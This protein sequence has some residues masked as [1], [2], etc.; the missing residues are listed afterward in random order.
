MQ[1]KTVGF[2]FHDFSQGGI[3]RVLA[4]L[5][6]ILVNGGYRVVM[7]TTI[8]AHS[9]EYD[10]P[11]DFDRITIGRYTPD[12][13]RGRLMREAIVKHKIDL[14]IHHE[15]YLSTLEEDVKVLEE[16]GVPFLIHLHNV[17]SNMYMRDN[18]QLDTLRFWQLYQRTDGLLVL[19]RVDKA[20]VSMLGIRAFY[21]PNPVDRISAPVRENDANRHVILWFA[22]FTDV[23]QPTHAL[24]IF[25]KV[26]ESVPDAEMYMLG[27]PQSQVWGKKSL[28]W[29]QKK[30]NVAG[31][32][33][34]EGFQPNVFKYLRMSDVTLVTSKF[35]GFCLTIME[36]KACAVPVVSYAM[37]YLE[38]TFP[39]EGVVSVP[40]GDV[41][42][43]AAE[44]IKVLSD[45]EYAARIADAGR[46]AYE[47]YMNIDLLAE[48]RKVFSDIE[49]CP[50]QRAI[51]REYTRNRIMLETLLLHVD[52]ALRMFQGK[53]G[54]LDKLLAAANAKAASLA[55][56]VDELKSRTVAG[57]AC[58]QD[59]KVV[60]DDAD[61]K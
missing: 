57:C 53:I 40:Q 39:D 6:R 58:S 15:Y 35:E 19:S 61:G 18:R 51:D 1:I 7:L 47:R 44:I 30:P 8:S 48:Y 25:E 29:V 49:A 4:N 27:D 50:R 21:M 24:Q 17:F 12:G 43:A 41:A 54:R 31:K 52:S 36:S 23:K 45:R 14:V 56:Q 26:L 60:G 38:T 10:V 34:F 3:Q 16:S 46:R 59:S 22:R 37:P 32:I 9:N 33:H 11:V 55:K 28:E 2:V 13:E 42:G 20:F 5:I